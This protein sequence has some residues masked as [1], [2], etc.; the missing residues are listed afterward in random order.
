MTI[1]RN[2]SN[3]P[4]STKIDNNNEMILELEGLVQSGRF[5][6]SELDQIYAILNL[7]R[8]FLRDQGI[9]NTITTRTGWSHIKEETGY[10]IWRFLP[11]RYSYNSLNNLYFNSAVL[12]N[13][14]EAS[15]ET[16]ETFD[17][18]QLYNGD[19]GAGYTDD[20]TEA[21]TEGGTEFDLLDSTND[22]LY[23]GDAT[24]FTGIKF[25]FHTRGSN[26]T[27][28][29][30]YWNGA[31]TE[32]TAN[33]DTLDDDTS[34][35]ESDGKISWDA[36]SDWATTTVNS[37]TKYWI[38]ISTTTTPV[39]T[40]KGYYIIPYN[41]VPAL[42]ALS[43]TQIQEED[44]AWCSYSTAI[45]VTVRNSGNASYE[46]DYF[47]DS[48]STSTNLENFFVHNNGDGYEADYED[49]GYDPVQAVSSA[50]SLTV[51]DGV[52]LVDASNVPS[53]SNYIVITLPSA[54]AIEGKRLTIKVLTTES[55][56]AG[57][58]IDGESGETI[59]G[60]ATYEMIVDY[61]YVTVISNGA[62]WNIISKS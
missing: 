15:S 5:N 23:I 44:W 42:L 6:K 51:D 16:A 56:N 7:D 41:S 10:S 33:S 25:E 2:N 36:L 19:S 9:G 20:T 37:V 46:G 8:K 50:T 55:G 4:N 24:T 17:S 29:V 26:N 54:V 59:D 48:A 38:R 28:K 12:E 35:F 13:R 14:G 30:E 61:D 62:S 47:I 18:V 27:L 53:G 3:L 32:V 49:S 39:T 43:S 40:A 22:Y 58:Q 57:V 31:W 1:Y 21:G 45:Y 34:D 60:I 52:V 11:T